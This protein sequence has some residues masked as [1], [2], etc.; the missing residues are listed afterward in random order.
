M[1]SPSFLSFAA[2][3]ALAALAP[4]TAAA[5]TPPADHGPTSERHGPSASDFVFRGGFGAGHADVLSSTD[6][7]ETIV[8]QSLYLGGRWKWL[9]LGVPLDAGSEIFGPYYVQSGPAVGATWQSGSGWRAGVM[10]QLG[11]AHYGR[12]HCGLFCESGGASADLPFV[13]LRLHGAYVF[14]SGSNTHFY[15]G[16][17]A[18]AS[19]DLQKK[20]VQYTTVGGLFTPGQESTSEA[21]MGGTRYAFVLQAGL[22][23]DL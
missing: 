8:T 18:F 20:A 16:A 3:L 17:E 1:R 6:G 5:Q 10:G 21:T 11:L 15:L 14:R 7:V 4:A 19:E 2:A 13:G 9:E 12:V 22:T 23:Y